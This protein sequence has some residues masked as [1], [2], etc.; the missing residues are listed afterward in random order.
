VIMDPCRVYRGVVI[1]PEVADAP[2]SLFLVQVKIGVA[3]RMA[4]L[5]LLGASQETGLRKGVSRS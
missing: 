2:F 3:V 1:G 4:L 5:Y